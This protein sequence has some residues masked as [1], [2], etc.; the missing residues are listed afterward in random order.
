MVLNET[1][2]Y[3]IYGYNHNNNDIKVSQLH[4]MRKVETHMCHEQGIWMIMKSLNHQTILPSKI[5]VMGR[6]QFCKTSPICI[7]YCGR[8]IHLTLRVGGMGFF[9]VNIIFF[10]RQ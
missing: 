1:K 2:Q 5:N 8:D 6:P 10:L 3:T 4:S 9:R 7:V